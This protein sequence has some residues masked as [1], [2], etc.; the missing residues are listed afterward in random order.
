[1]CLCQH[2]TL[3]SL[4]SHSVFDVLYNLERFVLS[5]TTTY[6]HYKFAVNSKKV[7][8]DRLLPD[9]FPEID[10]GYIF[11]PQFPKGRMH[12]ACCTFL[13]EEE[14]TWF[15]SLKEEFD[16]KERAVYSIVEH[17]EFW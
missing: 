6:E 15:A 4:A 9:T 17:K 2:P 14:G 3:K 5:A 1:V 16:S 12:R 13:K 8:H 7:S 10:G 11:R